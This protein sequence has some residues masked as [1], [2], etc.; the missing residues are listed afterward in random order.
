MKKDIRNIFIGL[1]L[2]IGSLYAIAAVSVPNTFTAGTG[3]KSADVNAN[4]SALATGVNAL[5]T[6]K[7]SRVTGVCAAGQAMKVINADGTVTCETVGA[8]GA[9]FGQTLTG[10]SGVGLTINSTST[11]PSDYGL[12]VQAKSGN[13]IHGV[14]T[15]TLPSAAGVSGANGNP[16]GIG[17]FGAGDT[18]VKGQ[19][20]TGVY[21]IGTQVGV[22]AT[23]TTAALLVD[24][25]IQVT[26]TNKAAFIHTAIAGSITNNVTCID[27]IATNNN[28]NA[29]VIITQ[30]FSGVYNASPTNVVYISN[31]WCISNSDGLT[32]M[33]VGT[34]FNVLVINQ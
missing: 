31:H 11:T 27:N 30:H 33:P 2:G 29:I 21:G 15:S 9:T 14:T 8:G 20:N 6:S 28:L 18:G 16:N 24:G 7:Q 12:D 1:L 22:S 17:V 3:I 25:P 5:E 23:G 10:S 34:T 32:P 26:G 13:A 19:G 4:F